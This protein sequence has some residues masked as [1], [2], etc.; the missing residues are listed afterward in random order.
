MSTENIAFVVIDSTAAS[1]SQRS[2][3]QIPFGREFFFRLYFHYY[4]QVVFI[5]VRIASIFEIDSMLPCA[6]SVI[7]HR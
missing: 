7:E 2:W 1:V 5:T 4:S 6:C 3:V